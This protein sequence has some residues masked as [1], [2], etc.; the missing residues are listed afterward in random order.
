M[1]KIYIVNRVESLESYLPNY[2]YPEKAF[3][4]ESAAVEYCAEMK[5]KLV[6]AN[7]VMDEINALTL[8]HRKKHHADMDLIRNG[9]E[10]LITKDLEWD[11][12]YSAL[13]DFDAKAPARQ[14]AI[15]DA[16]NSICQT[17]EKEVAAKHNV[18]IHEI[19]YMT[20]AR[21]FE[22]STLEIE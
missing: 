20:C 21:D 7:N 19:L 9:R 4:E 6:F 5:T 3:R 11:D 18:D 10:A 14:Q 16:F 13:E 17:I 8:P 2:R 1:N 15:Q 12:F 22:I